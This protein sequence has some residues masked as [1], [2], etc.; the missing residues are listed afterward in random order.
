[1]RHSSPSSPLDTCT[2]SGKI[3][4]VSFFDSSASFNFPKLNFEDS[5]A[6]VPSFEKEA[7]PNTDVLLLA[8][9]VNFESPPNKL[10]PFVDGA[11]P[12]PLLPEPNDNLSFLAPK[13]LDLKAV[14]NTLLLSPLVKVAAEKGFVCLLSEAPGLFTLT[15]RRVAKVS[16][17]AFLNSPLATSAVS[18][19]SLPSS[20]SSFVSWRS[21]PLFFLL[22]SCCPDILEA[23][24]ATEN[25]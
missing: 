21:A 19:S 25:Y 4:T 6:E 20:Y 7:P 12:N 23:S 10:V 11:L 18:S 14:P 9:K 3:E 13:P 17:S 24:K 16:A 1:M 2:F 15:I 8:P 5:V 22:S